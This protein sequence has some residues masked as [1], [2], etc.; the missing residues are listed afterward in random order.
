MILNAFS[1][2]DDSLTLLAFARELLYFWLAAAKRAS[3]EIYLELTADFIQMSLLCANI[4]VQLQ[5]VYFYLHWSKRDT[6]S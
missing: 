1:N 2:L 4:G 5:A 6:V 3:D